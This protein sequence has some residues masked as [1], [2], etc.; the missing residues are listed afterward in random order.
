MRYLNSAISFLCSAATG[1][2]LV[3]LLAV[4]G[5]FPT[6]YQYLDYAKQ[7]IAER[8]AEHVLSSPSVNSAP[9]LSTAQVFVSSDCLGWIYI[10]TYWKTEYELRISNG[11]ASMYKRRY[12]GSAVAPPQILDDRYLSECSL[13]SNALE[14]TPQETQRVLDLLTLP[15]F[16]NFN[17]VDGDR[18]TDSIST[19]MSVTLNDRYV[20]VSFDGPKSAPDRLGRLADMMYGLAKG[21]LDVPEEWPVGRK[22]RP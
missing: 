3:F 12:F 17:S 8:R 5:W 19:Q 15:N 14:L 7:Y 13:Q 16:L 2:L 22:C 9:N 18:T 4:T 1:G 6:F 20:H 11:T 21:R 10:C